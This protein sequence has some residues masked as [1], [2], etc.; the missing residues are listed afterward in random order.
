MKLAPIGRTIPI[1]PLLTLAAVLVAATFV[2]PRALE[3]E[4]PAPPQ[5][6]I[7][8]QVVTCWYGAHLEVV[9]V[10]AFATRTLQGQ[11]ARGDGLWLVLIVDVTNL[12]Q[13]SGAGVFALKVRDERDREFGRATVGTV[14]A[15]ALAGEL[16][17]EWE[18]ARFDPGITLRAVVTFQVPADAHQ[19]TLL[20]DP[21]QC[22]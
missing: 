17:V 21:F 6:L 16:G 13:E 19:F 10:D 12:D 18:N 8:Q 2:A 1:R 5:T 11:D 7:G 14:A 22:G 15:L 9:V 3:A 20:P 4:E